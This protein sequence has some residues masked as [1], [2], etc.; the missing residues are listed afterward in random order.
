MWHRLKLASIFLRCI[1]AFFRSRSR[2]AIVELALRQQLATFA[3]KGRRPRIAPADR[4]FWVL[5]SRMQQLREAFPNDTAPQ[6]LIFDNDSI[7]S[8][9][10]AESIENLGVEPRRT[11][12]RS[13]W[14]N[15][16]AKRW[17]GSV[18]RERLDHVVVLNEVHL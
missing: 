9:R 1:P 2:Q 3:E 5:L 14:Q 16:I 17:V 6:F 4:G 18:R 10:V 8:A 7:F 15:G 11:A 13:P 12:F